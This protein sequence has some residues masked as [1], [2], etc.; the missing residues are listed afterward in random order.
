M[1]KIILGIAVILSAAF[2][3]HAQKTGEEANKPYPHRGMKK[4]GKMWMKQLN[5]SDEQKQ[6]MKAA[7]MDFHKKMQDL[8]K[9]ENITVKEQRSRRTALIKE[10][11]QQVDAVLTP[12]QKTKLADLKKERTEKAKDLQ[13]KRFEKMKTSLGLSDEQSAKLKAINQSYHDKAMAIKS[14]A[15]LDMTKKHEAIKAL[16]AQRKKDTASILTTAQQEKM[17][18]MKERKWDKRK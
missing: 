13:A 4:S 10:H 8:N 12:E 3:A 9:E 16:A 18:Q 17:K 7:N 2:T 1:K 15:S 5:L 14:D 11:Q 6:Q